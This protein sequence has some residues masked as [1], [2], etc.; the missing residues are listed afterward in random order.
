MFR[1]K[2]NQ[3]IIAAL[4]II[5]LIVP[6]ILFSRPK[7]AE[8]QFV[9][10]VNAVWEGI[11]SVFTFI[12]TTSTVTDTG[13][14][15]KEY[16]REISRFFLQRLAKKFLEQTTTS[17]INWINTGFHGRPLFVENTESFFKDIAKSEIR[18]LVDTIGY[19]SLY[20]PFGRQT[21]LQ[22]I[23]AYKAQF[24]SN[25]QYSLSKVINDPALLMS[26]RN[27]FNIGGWNG[28]LINT[29]YPQ[30]NYLGFQ[31][32]LNDEKARRLEGT[33]QS[34]ADKVQTALQ[35]GL[36][37]LS[38]QTCPSNP[39]YNNEIDP[40]N[41]P[42][43]KYT[44]PYNPPANIPLD[45]FGNE[46]F[47]E[48]L[49]RNQEQ[50]A[51]YDAQY[52]AA[53]NTAYEQW[54]KENVCPGGLVTVTPGSVAANRIMSALGSPERQGELSA[55]MGN[56]LSAIFDNLINHFMDKGLTALATRVNPPPESDEW[57]YEGNTLGSPA[58]GNNT[59]W[60]TGPDEE[61]VLSD[62]KKQLEG[63]TLILDTTGSIIREEIGNTGN[64]TYVPGDI[65]NTETEI[66]LMD[67]ASV[68]EPGILQLLG[69]IWPQTRELDVCQPGP[70]LGWEKRIT[71]ESNRN[72]MKLQENMSN[73]DGNKAAAAQMVFNELKFA[74]SF[75][76][77]WIN[78]QMM[79]A[80]PNSIL[81]MDAVDEIKNLDQQAKELVDKR[82]A[83]SQA[84]A[85]LQAINVS[86]RAFTTQPAPGS[87]A[88]K[89]LI[90]LRKQYNAN[91]DAISN[92]FSIESA[93]NELAVA[94][95]KLANLKNLTTQC[96]TE[97]TENG[98]NTP[99]GWNSIKGSEGNEKALFC[100]LP[101]MGGYRHENF[102]I[103]NAPAGKTPSTTITHPEIP[104]VNAKNVFEYRE[105]VK[106]G[107]D[108][109]RKV[110]ILLSCSVIFETNPLDYKGN[111][112][113]ITTTIP[114]YEKP[115]NDSNDGSLIQDTTP[116]GST[117]S[118]YCAYSNELIYADVAT[119]EDC[120]ARGG[121]WLVS[122]E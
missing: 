56:S 42:T 13:L 8:A 120:S 23:D 51:A 57:S 41:R 72:S 98:W 43:F 111:I 21:A 90:S 113:G 50:L 7:K 17:T 94:K 119:Q 18:D 38:Q 31:L 87:G 60:N 45:L 16:A 34:K 36:G 37:F 108:K 88:E 114:S 116:I 122:Q 52:Q 65:A 47:S 3:Q 106:F 75:F 27:N 25:A 115:P 14:S 71:E 26:Y 121:S 117:S 79:M 82:R 95:D 97:R 91:K 48:N 63:K 59:V 92:T 109:N 4:I 77:D 70:D 15:L 5:A 33:V 58:S 32:M 28:F 107:F 19:N 76:A 9:D 89:S 30:N 39:S 68:A 74:V 78:N 83:K 53:K 104:L 55:A 12:N 64:G 10:P 46:S 85:R 22:T 103:P 96:N 73:T 110:N 49:R 66:K 1:N 20:F 6:T 99:G 24:E 105:D 80:L 40:Y 29:Q 35:Q 54:A 93:R 100:D 84:L 69:Q 81:Y 118:G 101:I 11:K 61:V 44:A 62:F 112:P 102:Q 2:K 67:N 86:L